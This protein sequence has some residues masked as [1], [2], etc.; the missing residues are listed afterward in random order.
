[1]EIPTDLKP[2]QRQQLADLVV[3][4]IVERTQRGKDKNGDPFPR[5]SKSYIKSLD[6]ANAGKSKNRVDLTLSGDMLAAL[7]L[8]RHRN[9]EIVIGFDSGTVENDK[10]EGNILGSYGKEPNP[11]KA[12]DFLGIQP[13]KLRELIRYVR[14]DDG[15]T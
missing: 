7:K 1:M 9:G 2:D 3:E 6:F 11:S 10:A 14:S 5:Y 12:R 8:L 4:H 15:D 13:A